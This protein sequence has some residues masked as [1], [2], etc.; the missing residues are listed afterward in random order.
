M[1]VLSIIVL[2]QPELRKFFE[3]TASI[4]QNRGKPLDE[5][6][7]SMIAESMWRLSEKGIGAIIVISGR[8]NIDQWSNGGFV[9]DGQPS[10]PL[11]MSIFDPH[12]PGHDGALIIKNGKFASFGVRIPVSQSGRLSD[13]Y[14]TR[15]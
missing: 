1:A 4:R 2:F 3:R 14:G 7:S 6:F 9:L 5:H 10:L 15:H 11:I 8:E 13:E 12:S